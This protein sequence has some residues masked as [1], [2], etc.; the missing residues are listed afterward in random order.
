MK[1]KK[2]G[3]IAAMMGMAFAGNAMA[4]GW[5]LGAEY[6]SAK[7]KESSSIAQGLVDAV[8]GSASSVQDTSV[9]V[10]KIFAGYGFTENFG[11]ELGYIS[12]GSMDASF[13]GVSGS[14]IAYAGTASKKTSGFD[15]AAIIR[16][17]QSSGLNGLFFRAG[18]HTLTVDTTVSLSVGASSGVT[19]DSTSGS[20]TLYGIGYDANISKN[21]D[22]RIAY[23][24][25]NSI[26]GVSGNDANVFS[27]GALL[28]F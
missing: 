24:A 13:S 10:G 26:G 12:S 23:T 19:N 7:E 5:Y 9:G 8:G 28:K 15:Y 11:V 20:G 21:A 22:L 16:P 3:V 17:S 25:Y 14:S 27:L 18:G 4:E 2:I 6:G 1:L